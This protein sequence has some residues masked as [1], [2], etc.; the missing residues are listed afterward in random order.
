MN[1][2]FTGYGTLILLLFALA[3]HQGY[4][5]NSLF[6]TAKHT[7]PGENHYHK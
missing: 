1:K 3:A 4:A 5:W 2:I 6:A 7:G